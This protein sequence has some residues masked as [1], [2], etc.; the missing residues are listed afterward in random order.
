[1]E[2]KAVAKYIRISPG[3]IRQVVDLIRGKN[4]KEALA[5]LRFTPKRASAVVEKVVKSAVANA[6]HNYEMNGEKLYVAKVYVDQ[7]PTWKRFKP[8]AMGRADLVRRKTSHI[9]V[10]V[11]EK[12]V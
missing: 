8:R 7:G 5:I 6:E 4:V 11:S 10:V 9:T 2:A 1:M 3:K 12:E